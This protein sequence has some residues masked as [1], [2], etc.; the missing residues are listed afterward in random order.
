MSYDRRWLEDQGSED[1]HGRTLWS[2]GDCARR[3]ADPS[4]RRW[5]ADLFKTALPAVEEFSSPRAW[6][7]TLLG[8]D[9]YCTLGVN[10]VFANRMRKILADRLML[11]FS[12]N[13]RP[14][15][16][17][18]EN[19]LA[20]D[21]ARLPQA[22][23]Q[24]GLTTH[25][26]S[27]ISAGLQ[28]LRWLMSLQTSPSGYFR[29]VG[30]ESFG[31]LY[32]K[33]LAF[34]QQPVEASATIGACIAASR[35]DSA[36]EWRLGAMSAFNWFVGENDLQ[37][38]LID[39]DTGSCSDGLHPDRANQNKGAESA[40]SY[41]SGLVDIR[42]FERIAAK[43]QMKSSSVA[44]H[45]VSKLPITTTPVSGGQIVSVAFSKPTNVISTPRSGEGGRSAI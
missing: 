27:Y 29:P 40:L 30:T 43:D 6:T 21:N 18:F 10:D 9:A 2:L 22:L 19:L 31:K 23:I 26:S 3:G 12:E 38:T 35:A 37:T 34:D 20:Y 33:P 1:S 45:G 16:L 5:A 8:L 14:E 42:Q 17:W 32:E 28:S 39:P 15:W 11:L 24:T 25:S 4:R 7:F 41:L 13:Q 36:P 44:E